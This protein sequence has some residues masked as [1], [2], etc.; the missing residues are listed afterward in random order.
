MV[1]A[2]GWYTDPTNADVEWFWNG[3]AYSEQ[4]AAG[5]TRKWPAGW[6]P[7]DRN[8]QLQREWSGTHW[9]GATRPTKRFLGMVMGGDPKKTAAAA[10]QFDAQIRRLETAHAAGARGEA[11]IAWRAAHAVVEDAFGPDAG[12]RWHH[13]LTRIG[14]DLAFVTSPRIGSV[15]GLTGGPFEV[16]EDFV[17]F[18]DYALDTDR[19]ST[20]TVFQDGQKHVTVANVTD[21]RGKIR[22]VQQVHDLRT[23][24]IQLSGPRGTLRADIH[25]DLAGNA[26][27]IAAQFNAKM[28]LLAP[29]AVTAAELQAMVDAILSASG[30]P[31]AEKLQQLDRLRYERLLSDDDW[32]RAKARILDNV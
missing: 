5:F 19:H 8:P 9:T 6:Y 23:A 20:I 17:T 16:F 25:P 29:S 27:Q 26:Q 32:K 30:Q 12:Y 1:A 28:K 13:T 21:K 31:A 15:A 14:F 24:A 22:A 3:T 7:V 18:G 11:Q 4:R 10:L 2:P